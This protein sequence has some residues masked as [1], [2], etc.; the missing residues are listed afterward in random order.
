MVYQIGVETRNK[1]TRCNNN[2]RCLHDD[3]FRICPV[4]SK[5]KEDIY[6]IKAVNPMRGCNYCLAFGDSHICRCPTRSELYERYKI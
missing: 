5:I 4:E 3:S 2:F 1:T 6:F